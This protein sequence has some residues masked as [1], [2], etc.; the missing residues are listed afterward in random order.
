MGNTAETEMTFWS[1]G[2]EQKQTKKIK[3][4][5]LSRD[6]DRNWFGR[7]HTTLIYLL[8]LAAQRWNSMMSPL[9]I[10][11]GRV[12]QLLSNKQQRDR[13]PYQKNGLF[14]AQK[15]IVNKPPNLNYFY[16]PP[17]RTSAPTINNLCLTHRQA[18][19]DVFLKQKPLFLSHLL[20]VSTSDCV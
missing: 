7:C 15:I 10:P 2:L 9:Q 19:Y 5:N 12:I 14:T 6:Y 1:G 8:S 3:E 13:E 11:A 17:L 18:N 20:S 4:T 16:K